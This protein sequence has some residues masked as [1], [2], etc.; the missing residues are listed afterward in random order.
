M[1]SLISNARFAALPALHLI[2]MATF[3]AGGGWVWLAG[4]LY[5]GGSVL[6]DE[7]CA[8]YRAPV[9]NPNEIFLNSLLYAIVPLTAL[10]A[11]ALLLHTASPGSLMGNAALAMGI[12]SGYQGSWMTVGGAVFT[13][14]MLFGGTASFAHE[15]FH[16]HGRLE[17]S[18]SQF[19]LAQCLYT[20]MAIEHIHGHHRN[21]GLSH[22][23]TT[24]PR[25]MTAW[26]FVLRAFI[27]TYR[28]AA[29]I[30]AGRMKRRN[31]PWFSWR[32]RFLQGLALQTAVC[33]AIFAV[34]GIHGLAGFAASA[35]MSIVIIDGTNY[36]AH[37]G[38]VRV[39]GGRVRSRHSW[40]SPRFVT[41]SLLLN[42]Q[43]HSDHHLSVSRPYWE[44]GV[45]EDAPV[46]P[47]GM[48]LMVVVALVPPLWFRIIEPP[49]EYWD[50]R[51][52]SP[53]ELALLGDAARIDIG[54][55]T[56]EARPAG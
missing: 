33:G 54:K 26:R 38:I 1:K 49:L 53:G 4:A 2:A 48:G 19:L 35:V 9:S 25:G 11:V 43:R 17:W 16:R 52:A 55:D 34:G 32:N 46:H 3:L 42:V 31:W 28:N 29:R 20:P 8:D 14:A 37:Y 56:L 15:L 22:D 24:A 12:G 30:E 39:F 23:P 44:L 47:L 6:I 5:V 7:A 18:L 21:V 51:F 41:T 50:R 27:G 40:N 45:R 13:V 36:V 10:N